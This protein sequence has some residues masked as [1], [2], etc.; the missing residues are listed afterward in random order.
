MI[1][2]GALMSRYSRTANLD[3]REVYGK[4]F[5]NN[6]DRASNFYKRIFLDYGDESVA[7]LTTAQMGIQNVS[8]IVT[9]VIEEPRI[10]LSYLE[11]SSRYV[12]YNK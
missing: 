11:K 3:I 8:N 2:R 6:P 10:G 7:E 9:K 5:K 1:D 12:K 4:E